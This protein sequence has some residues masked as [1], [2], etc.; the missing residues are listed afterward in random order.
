MKSVVFIKQIKRIYLHS[1]IDADTQALTED[2]FVDTIN[3]YDE[4]ALEKALRIRDDGVAGDVTIVTLGTDRAEGAL[5]WGL[6]MGADHAVHA[7]EKEATFCD[8][9]ITA[10]LLAEAISG[11][12]F[13][14]F[15]FG[16]MA[17]DDGMGQVGTFFAALKNLPVVTAVTDLTVMPSD[18]TAIARRALDRGNKEEVQVGL[19]AVF[20]ADLSLSQPRYPTFDGRKYA[21]AKTIERFDA[22]KL[23]SNATGAS[24][25][26][27]VEIRQVMPP[28]IR[29]KKILAPDSGLS[30][31]GRMR[32]VMSGGRGAKSSG[33]IEGGS[34]KLAKGIY[35]YL[36]EKRFLQDHDDET[37]N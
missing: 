7:F 32:F 25:A 35:A 22:E 33:R 13:D 36:N 28:K 19:P 34:E 8:P 12:G 10:R 16:R 31:A 20:T 15:F 11:K 23:K 27:T 6:A 30:A 14:L 29:P 24:M 9:W 3:P 37:G 2:G 4:V 26:P 17:L 18:R 21:A 5:R 1:G